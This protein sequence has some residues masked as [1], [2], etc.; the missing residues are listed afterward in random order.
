VD[1]ATVP[2]ASTSTAASPMSSV[3]SHVSP[4]S[5]STRTTNPSPPAAATGRQLAVGGLHQEA[6]LHVRAR[7]PRHGGDDLGGRR[8]Q[9]VELRRGGRRRS[10]P[11]STRCSSS[12]LLQAA[13]F[14]ARVEKKEGGRGIDGHFP[15]GADSDPRWSDDLACHVSKSGKSVKILSFLC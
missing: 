14:Q 12:S 11:S 4:H 1:A 13:W 7:A 10:L 6:A 9:P 2:A 5:S 15:S 3:S 8:P